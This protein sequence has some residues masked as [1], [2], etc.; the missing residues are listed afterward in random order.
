MNID[1]N[2]PLDLAEIL[3][4][5]SKVANGFF[6]QGGQEQ[7]HRAHGAYSTIHTILMCNQLSLHRGERWW[8]KEFLICNMGIA[9]VYDALG[10]TRMA[11]SLLASSIKVSS[12]YGIRVLWVL[13]RVW[14]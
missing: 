1:N 6:L 12:I 2:M 11:E 8:Q 14:A 7:L 4:R 5:Q 9:R 3:H 10:K 13:I